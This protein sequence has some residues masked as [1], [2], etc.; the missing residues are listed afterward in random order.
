MCVVTLNLEI[1][2]NLN[3]IPDLP[4]ERID[5]LWQKNPF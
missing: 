5:L 1:N 2:L 3:R 4:T